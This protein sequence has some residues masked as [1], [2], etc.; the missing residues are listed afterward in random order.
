ML[1]ANI[2]VDFPGEGARTFTY[3]VP[4]D[5]ALTE[6]DIVWVPF[7]PG[8]R[9][10]IVMGFDR[11]TDVEEIKP[12][13]AVTAGGPFVSKHLLPA[14]IWIADYY[15]ANLFT[16]LSLML[17][18]GSSSR[19]RSWVSIG[20]P[21]S[22]LTKREKQVIDYVRAHEKT[23]KS[24]TARRLGYGGAAV[25]DSLI[26]RGDLVSESEWEKPRVSSV[27]T[28]RY[29]SGKKH[30]QLD[31][32]KN[33]QK[34][35]RKNRRVDLVEWASNGGVATTKNQLNDQFGQAASKWALDAG[36]IVEEQIRKDRDPLASYVFQQEF[37]HDPT[38]AQ[39]S[40]I[41]EIV[42]QVLAAVPA[43]TP[44]DRRFLLHG[45][46]GSG[47]TEVYLQ[48]IEACLAAGKRALFL[49]PEIALTPQT[50]TRIAS[51][52]PGKIGVLH[53]G[54]SIGQRYDQWW[55]IKN[56]ELPIVLGSRGAIF[57]P[58]K[59]LGLIVIDE[60]H[61]W[62]YKQGDQSPRYHARSVA[63]FLSQSTGAPLVVGSAT[64]DIETY[65]ASVSD[66]YRRLSLPDRVREPNGVSPQTALAKVEIVDMRNELDDGHFEMLSRPLIDAMAQTI[67][68]GLKTILFINR[69]GSASFV[70]CR[71]CGVVRHCKR[72]DS[73]LTFHRASPGGKR[74]DG[75]L[76]CHYCSYSVKAGSNC[77][78][79]GG[80]QMTRSAPGTEMAVKTVEQ[81]FPGVE[82]LR[83]D[84]D[85][86]KSALD[87]QRIMDQFSKSDASVLVGTQMVAKGLDIPSVTLVGVL[88]ADTGL[89]VPDFRA[90]ERAFQI[91]TQVVGRS[92]RGQT[93]GRAIVQTFN[94]DHYA[95]QA[96]ADQ[97]YQY[98]YET[99]LRMRADQANPPF[100]RIVKLTHAANDYDRA[101]VEADR[102]FRELE[103]VR[104]NHGETS[105]EIIGPSPG[106]PLR[107]RNLYRWQILL[108]GS[109]PEALIDLVSPGNIWSIDVD[110]IN[111][112]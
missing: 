69:R 75:R 1:Y 66:R 68:R 16:T 78:A 15:R 108:K 24:R 84:S 32:I 22:E 88:S 50:I 8:I 85:S 43:E 53:S 101:K 48:A 98:F 73:A 65:R 12:I 61:E 39:K 57:A 102:L 44:V 79:C 27:F 13:S 7:G 49:V 97:D 91:L 9:Q 20:E 94:P 82:V 36:V 21:H 28:R 86:A 47:K 100:T 80:S 19:L 26:R 18:P 59:D 72:C 71:Q 96:A 103:E 14:A 52:F 77:P 35:L 95:I 6:G 63:E 2:A 42:T 30:E 25:V 67:E 40:A 58:L 105:T 87:H 92:G 11:H 93:D 83:W 34:N 51:R 4:D 76:V 29:R 54:L 5:M 62:T 3:S 70:Q 99:E 106:Y 64:P 111:I 107:I 46:T 10:G 55:R 45:V 74:K 56:G 37:A 38:P 23:P 31:R 89:A 60:E 17:P 81:Y 90:H 104:E 41:D 112:S 33:E 110:P 109:R